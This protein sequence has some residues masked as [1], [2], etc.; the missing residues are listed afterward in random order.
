[1]N[2]LALALRPESALPSDAD[3]AVL[4][5]RA[6]IE[7]EGPVPVRVTPQAVFDLSRLAPTMSGLLEL[8]DVASAVRGHAGRRLAA[9]AEVLAN[10]AHDARDPSLPWLLAPC[11]LQAIKA[12]GVTFVA[13]MLERVIEEQARGDAS[14]AES[15]RQAV[16]AVI[17]E[18]LS[19]VRPGSPEAAKLKDVLI[20]Q[21]LWSQY[22]EVGIGPDAEVFTK[23]QPMS[24]VGTGAQVGLH[25][26]SEWNNPEPEVVLAV[27]SRGSVK[28]AALGNDVNLR[29][30]E[31]RSALLLGKAK[32]NNGSCAIG[33]FVR[34]FDARFSLDTVRQCELSMRVH[35][36]DG[37][38]LEGASS[39]AR[40]SRDP[41]ELVAQTRGSTHQYP[42]G[43]MLFLG[44]M[45]AP[46][47]DRLGPGQGFTHVRGDVVT[48][49]TPSLGTLAN[50]VDTS[51]RI[52]PWTY[53]TRAL[54]RDLARR[55]LLDGGAP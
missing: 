19:A 24:A 2:D 49:G 7:G 6:W 41:A 3:A 40:I 21:G 55:G 50:R 46:T 44:T 23:S 25:P 39:L 36:P 12:A 5:G 11:D 26:K 10:S 1:M 27:D 20:A 48:V 9:T 52:P 53:G 13:S 31:G 8:D 37:F 35:G 42:D 30:F 14:R 43:F 29:D 54:M 34:L 22:L 47:Q 33:P 38:V 15:V 45:F 4:V 16:V 32:D 28:G 17:G 18:N 51:D